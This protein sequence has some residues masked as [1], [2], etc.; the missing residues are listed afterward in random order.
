MY[1]SSRYEE[2]DSFQFKLPWD[3][4]TARGFG[5]ALVIV[6]LGVFFA[7]L[8]K[9]EKP[10]PRDILTNTVPVMLLNFG[11]GDGTGMSKGNL[12]P[13]GMAHKGAAPSNSL[14]DA[15]VAT[16]SNASKSSQP[17]IA[18]ASHYKPVENPTGDKSDNNSG[19][20]SR[21]VGSG[22]GTES[23][24]GL[25]NKGYGSGL[26]SGLGDI[27]WGGGGNRTVLHKKIPTYPPGVQTSGQIKIQFTVMPDGTV[28]KM[29]PKQKADPRLE[30]AAMEALRQWRFN[31]LKDNIVMV[32]TIT[33]SFKLR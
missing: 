1:K 24:T 21:N 14:A 30:R 8:F 33:L 25:G 2:N 17:D 9:I 18:D 6:S 10:R 11:D 29:V 23:G 3:K 15:E 16:Q 31:P 5:I 4:N 12:S 13:E 32:G 22:S 26:G 20:S 28:G 7:S 19:S 27:E